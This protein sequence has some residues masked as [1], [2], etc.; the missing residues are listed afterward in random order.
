LWFLLLIFNVLLFNFGMDNLIEPEN[1][2]GIE[3]NPDDKEQGFLHHLEELRQRIFKA[4]VAILVGC[5][6]AGYF[7]NDIMKYVLL[8]PA[9]D[10][11]LE[12]QNLRPFGQQFLYFKVIFAVGI[13][14]AFP[15]AIYQI[16]KFIEPGLYKHERQW[17]GKI[18]LFTTLCFALGVSFAYFVML[19]GMLNFTAGF[20]S[21][22]IKNIIDVTEYFGFVIT[23]V[24]G[25]GLIFELP[26]VTFVLASIGIV[27]AA[28][29]SKFRRYAVVLILIIAA[30]LTPSPDPFNQL[31]FAC[32]LYVLYELSIVIARFARRKEPVSGV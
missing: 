10:A 24:L 16:W 21:A 20:G 15:F 29:M 7:V 11:R 13:V 9:T 14:L 17:A 4:V 19:P 8:K 30:V 2:E 25:A 3:H 22:S 12:L 5:G 27:T 1:R 6:I 23:T 28:M 32:P 31:I 18:T 26:M